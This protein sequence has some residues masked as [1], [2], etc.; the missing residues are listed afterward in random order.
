MR[1]QPPPNGEYTEVVKVFGETPKKAV[2]TTALPNPTGW[3]QLRT[4]VRSFHHE[5]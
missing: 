2:E 5:V 3:M 4:R 1:I